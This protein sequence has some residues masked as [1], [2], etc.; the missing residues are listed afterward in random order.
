MNEKESTELE[1][2]EQAVRDLTGVVEKRQGVYIP[3]RPQRPNPPHTAFS[4][5]A[6]ADDRYTFNNVRLRWETDKAFLCEIGDG[7]FWVPKSQID[8]EQTDFNN[9]VVTTTE[10]WTQVS[11]AQEVYDE[12]SA[13]AQ[14]AQSSSALS[15]LPTASKLFRKLAM[16]YHPD[17]NSDAVEFVTDLNE[18]W[19]AVRADTKQR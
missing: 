13:S 9:H 6:M 1:K 17:R 11:R 5:K 19:Q 2:F 14:P 3:R 4:V 18:L 8:W 15:L 10:W 16:K 12:G 7:E